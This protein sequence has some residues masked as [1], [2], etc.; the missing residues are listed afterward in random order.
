MRT[1]SSKCVMPNRTA[2]PLPQSLLRCPRLHVHRL[3]RHLRNDVA[4]DRRPQVTPLVA[5]P[6]AAVPFYAIYIILAFATT[7]VLFYAV[8]VV[9]QRSVPTPPP[10]PVA[11]DAI[12][13]ACLLR[14]TNFPAPDG[15]VLC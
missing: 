8:C 1:N 12:G 6:A 7:T 14:T 5:T 3:R 13:D 9:F 2:M 10:G 11:R 4:W 15:Q